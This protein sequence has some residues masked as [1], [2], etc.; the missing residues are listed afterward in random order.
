MASVRRDVDPMIAHVSD[1][2]RT[3]CVMNN[4]HLGTIK[5]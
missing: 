1:L 2:M 5:D 4:R 3:A